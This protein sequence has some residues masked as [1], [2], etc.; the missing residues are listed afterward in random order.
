M[1]QL[2]PAVQSRLIDATL[3]LLGS[4]RTRLRDENHAKKYILSF[5]YVYCGLAAAVAKGELHL[6]GEVEECFQK[7]SQPRRGQL[8]PS[9]T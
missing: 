2:D 5:R 1:S 4:T 3:G 7:L 6:E 8:P 9:T